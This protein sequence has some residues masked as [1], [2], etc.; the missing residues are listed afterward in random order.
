MLV[1]IG[2]A[3]DNKTTKEWKIASKKK[4]DAHHTGNLLLHRLNK[5]LLTNI[6]LMLKTSEKL[7]KVFLTELKK[8]LLL[9]KNNT[10]PEKLLCKK[11]SGLPQIKLPPL[12]AATLPAL[13]NVVNKTMEIASLNATADK[14]QSQLK[15][16]TLMLLVL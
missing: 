5:H 8:N 13:E 7:T 4:L 1:E 2:N 3:K 10:T 9:L 6:T 11:I 14:E 12:S 15:K 16:P